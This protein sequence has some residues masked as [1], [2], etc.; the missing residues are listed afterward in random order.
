[1]LKKGVEFDKVLLA[2]VVRILE[3]NNFVVVDGPDRQLR[4]SVLLNLEVIK[5]EAESVQ[6]KIMLFDRGTIAGTV[7]FIATFVDVES[8]R[9]LEK[10]FVG[11]EAVRTGYFTKERYEEVLSEAYCRALNSFADFR[12]NSERGS[13][14]GRQ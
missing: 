11:E 1:M 2:D 10:T 4:P 9:R 8:E 6:P 3:F 14:E 7:V 12:Y 13:K 5:A